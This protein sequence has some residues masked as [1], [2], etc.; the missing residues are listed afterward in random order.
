MY[1][2]LV[3]VVVGGDYHGTRL[4]DGGSPM[5]NG[6]LALSGAEIIITPNETESGKEPINSNWWL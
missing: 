5:L 3:V 6:H 1:P 2:F 4:L